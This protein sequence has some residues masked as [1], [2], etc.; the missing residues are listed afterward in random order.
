VRLPDGRLAVTAQALDARLDALDS[1]VA[2]LLVDERFAEAAQ[3]QEDL[4]GL[5]GSAA[6]ER[7]PAARRSL[8]RILARSGASERALEHL[9]GAFAEE[10]PEDWYEAAVI[11][12]RAGDHVSAR[13]WTESGLAHSTAP[14]RAEVAECLEDIAGDLDAQ[15]AFLRL[16]A[17]LL[18]EDGDIEPERDGIER[19]VRALTRLERSYLVEA[20]A[21][22]I[23][24]SVPPEGIVPFLGA[25]SEVDE[26]GRDACLALATIVEPSLA[27]SVRESLGGRAGDRPSRPAVA[28]LLG[29]RPVAAWATSSLDAPDQQQLVVTVAKERGRLSPLVVLVDLDQLGGAVKDAFFLPDMVEPRLR[30]ELSSPR[31][32]RSGCRACRW[33]RT[34]RSRW[35]RSRSSARPRSGGGSPRC[36]TSRCSSA[37][38]AGCCAPSAAGRAAVPSPGADQA[39]RRSSAALVAGTG[40][41][42][43]A[44]GTAAGTVCSARRGARIRPQSSGAAATA[45]TAAA[46]R[47]PMLSASAA[48]AVSPSPPSARSASRAAPDARPGRPTS[49]A[50]TAT[51]A[52][53]ASPTIHTCT[54]ASLQ[55]GLSLALAWRFPSAVSRLATARR[56]FPVR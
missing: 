55:G 12:Y 54:A 20:M 27:R 18:D 49:H 50:A 3:A 34:R 4:V 21:E 35:S 33:T 42:R 8:A 11:A 22:S 14:E 41:G 23:I 56:P 28:G 44:A 6:P 32:S 53:S 17:T 51:S 25:V 37:S 30:R 45:A 29:A 47:A 52:A 26:G 9:R 40:A 46:S 39:A 43:V 1:A 38:S 31:W 15:A 2:A 10:D 48:M 16:R 13:R 36:S 7:V 5:L 24:A 19:V